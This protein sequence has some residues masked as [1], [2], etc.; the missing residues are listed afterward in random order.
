M[1]RAARVVAGYH[2]TREVLALYEGKGM[3]PLRN[4][5]E[6]PPLEESALSV[7]YRDVDSRNSN[8]CI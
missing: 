6:H 2:K 8:H 5:R 4:K 1:Q 7:K 3:Q